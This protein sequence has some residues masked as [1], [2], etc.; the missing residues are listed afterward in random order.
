MACRR[1]M[2]SMACMDRMAS[3]NWGD[4]RPVSITDC[5]KYG[6]LLGCL[7]LYEYVVPYHWNVNTYI[8]NGL[9]I[10]GSSRLHR[11]PWMRRTTSSISPSSD[12]WTPSFQHRLAPVSIGLQSSLM[13]W[14]F[15]YYTSEHL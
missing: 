11:I 12:S 3:L 14:A 9:C 7:L 15:L 1:N 8:L 5:R 13:L 2:S 4:E 6:R 10:G